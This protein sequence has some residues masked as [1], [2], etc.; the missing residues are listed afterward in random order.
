MQLIA[1]ILTVYMFVG[2]LFPRTDFS[3]LEKLPNLFSHYQKHVQEAEQGGLTTSFGA[4]LW[5]H[6]VTPNQ[7]RHADDSHQD[8]PFHSIDVSVH[9][10][11]HAV[12]L[13]AF[14]PA[15]QPIHLIA[16]Y[17]D[18]VSADRTA[19]PFRPPIL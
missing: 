16:L 5:Q 9:L 12:P 10:M 2:S 18:V 7:H 4:F 15:D 6:F 13:P 1:Q 17:K 11:M 3:Q 8:L 19:P 14:I